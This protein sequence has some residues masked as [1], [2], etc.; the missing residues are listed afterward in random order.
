ME[1]TQPPATNLSHL[2][3]NVR[4]MIAWDNKS[5]IRKSKTPQWFNYTRA[6]E[7]MA[8]MKKFMELPQKDRYDG[9]VIVAEANNGKTGLIRKFARQYPGVEKEDGTGI[10]LP[11]VLI[12]SP[13]KADISWL[14]SEIQVALNA[15]YKQS[16]KPEGKLR[17]IQELFRRICVEMLIIDEIS[18]IVSG[19]AKQQREFL[20]F[21][22]Q[23]STRLEI[24][25]VLSG[26][27]PIL[28][29]LS[30]DDQVWSRFKVERIPEWQADGEFLGLLKI[31]ERNAPLKKPSNLTSEAN[32]NIALSILEKSKGRIGWIIE[33]LEEAV[34][35]AI[36]SG[37]ER[38]TQNII[39]Q[40]EVQSPIVV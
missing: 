23:M 37:E 8:R 24:P 21:V 6:K 7:I 26:T 12:D 11:V 28:S 20:S 34:E 31:Y 29:A 4:H 9:I 39:D 32:R 14:L 40:I 17:Q 3:E 15:P 2:N 22:K 16:E 19:T 27:P 25:I 10:H 35:K 18:D 33:I 30:T 1:N 36:L 13:P 38:I 5:R